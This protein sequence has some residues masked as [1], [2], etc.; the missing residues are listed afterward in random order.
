MRSRY[1]FCSLNSP[2]CSG[3][4]L[5]TAS[6]EEEPS[7]CPSLPPSTT[8]SLTPLPP[9]PT[10]VYGTSPC[11]C[12]CTYILHYA[13]DTD[14]T[15][16]IN[17]VSGDCQLLPL[18]WTVKVPPDHQMLLTVQNISF[19]CPSLQLNIRDG[20]ERRDT[21]LY[22][23]AVDTN[24]S[25][26]VRSS[27]HVARLE[28]V[29]DTRWT[30]TT[31]CYALMHLSVVIEGNRLSRNLKPETVIVGPQSWHQEIYFLVAWYSRYLRV[32]QKLTND[33]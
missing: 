21:L 26:S 22:T 7:L 6:C 2:L 8:T 1:R 23:V 20:V 25:V 13:A 15:R 16:D 10:P 30:N 28:L 29:T 9:R 31:I 33:C 18:T 12:G 14:N 19:S 4:R 27:D 32:L 5:E 3:P 24:V 11:E 17:I